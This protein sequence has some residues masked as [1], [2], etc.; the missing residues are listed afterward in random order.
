M[1]DH[2]AGSAQSD[3]CSGC[4]VQMQSMHKEQVGFIPEQARGREPLVCYRCYRMKHYNEPSPLTLDDSTFTHILHQVSDTDSLVVNIVDL[5]DFEG[6]LITGLRRFVGNNPIMLVVNKADLIPKAVNPNK[7]INWIQRQAKAYGLQVVEVVLCSALKNI[8][9]DRLIAAINRHRAGKDVYVV[10][11]TN[12]GKSTLINRLLRSVG[13]A[14]ERL[15]TSRYP[16]TTLDLVAIPLDDGRHLF[17][18][19]G[20]MQATRLTECVPASLLSA[21]IPQKEI[22]PIVYQLKAEQTLF[23]GA[24]ARL[25]FIEGKPQSMTCYLSQMIPIHRTKLSR[26]DEL[27]EKHKGQMLSPPDESQLADLPP[28]TKHD[29]RIR[30]GELQDVVISGLGWIKINGMTG[31]TLQVHGPSGVSVIT[32]EPMI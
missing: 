24:L 27:Y 13:Q 26:A 28:F 19:P 2:H 12:V 16:G 30:P 1:T 4:G 11:A 7:L 29:I 9:L 3:F 10:G 32:R 17:D 8:G 6:S 31:A 25:D 14:D 23:F 20:I 21:I 22:K 18:T 15:T 5:F